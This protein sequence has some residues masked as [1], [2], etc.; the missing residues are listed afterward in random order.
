MPRLLD[1]AAVFLTQGI[2]PAVAASLA[3]PCSV[4]VSQRVRE[5]LDTQVWSPAA[6]SG[7][8]S[9]PEG[10]PFDPSKDVLGAG[11]ERLANKTMAEWEGVC[12]ADYCE[13]FGLCDSDRRSTGS[14]DKGVLA[15]AKR[16]C[17]ASAGKCFP[18][19]GGV[20]MRKLYTQFTRHWCRSLECGFEP[21]EEGTSMSVI[22]EVLVIFVACLLVFAVIIT[23][24]ELSGRRGGL[25]QQLAEKGFVSQGFLRACFRAREGLREALGIPRDKNF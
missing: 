7:L 4:S 21:T 18:F 10:C 2:L 3:R 15:A 1:V 25:A 24:V 19:S 11:A 22:V 17:E 6:A 20:H 13:I 23:G 16:R 14:C 8:R 9:W 5:L 12:L